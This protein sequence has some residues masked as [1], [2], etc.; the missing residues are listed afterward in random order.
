MPPFLRRLLPLTLALSCAAHAAGV[1]GTDTDHNGIRDDVDAYI[2]GQTPALSPGRAAAQE[3][4]RALQALLTGAAPAATG[5]DPLLAL[6]EGGEPGW[7]EQARELRTRTVNTGARLDAY[8]RALEAAGPRFLALQ[9][10]GEAECP[11]GGCAVVVFQNGI[12]TS[13][14]TALNSVLALRRMLG[15]A[16]GDQRLLYALNYNPTEGLRDF[17]EVFRQK[18]GEH[19]LGAATFAGTF[20][21]PAALSAVAAGL[22]RARLAAA[23]QPPS[24]VAGW[25]TALAHPASLL[26]RTDT[27][28]PTPEE[29]G[30][31]VREYV[32]A[33]LGQ[34]VRATLRLRER[35]G[36]T[37]YMDENARQLTDGIEAYLRRGLRVV[38]VAHSQGNLYAEVVT[39][40]LAR[41]GLPTS[42]FAVVGIAVPN[43]Q[44]AAGGPYVSTQAD[45]VLGALRVLFPVLEAN[46]R[47]VP[48]GQP[49][50]AFLGH[51]FVDVYT[52]PGS[53]VSARVADAVREA[54]ARVWR[55]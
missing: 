31:A 12:L 54:V 20:G 38:L 30:G 27:L 32:G 22:F 21:E 8:A 51:A 50:G 41:R 13:E 6:L 52:R 26:P 5:R 10:G 46:D 45:L 43:G 1:A 29:V 42:H 37:A 14:E 47:T 15:N 33:Y 9:P 16:A 44:P 25:I 34:L 23:A 18:F 19:D 7:A 17:A 35:T 36:A 28:V 53:A 3:Y 49:G 55:P 24:T 48:A 4:A 40:E 39:R 11:A 2:A